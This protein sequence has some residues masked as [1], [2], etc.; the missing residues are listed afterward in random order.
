[1]VCHQGYLP[2]IQKYV[3]QS[4]TIT[5]LWKYLHFSNYRILPKLILQILWAKLTSDSALCNNFE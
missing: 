3:L 1:M 5:Q 4:F 2:S